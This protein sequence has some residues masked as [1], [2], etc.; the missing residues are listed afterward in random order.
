[1]ALP[2]ASAVKVEYRDGEKGPWK[3]LALAAKGGSLRG[4]LVMDVPVGTRQRWWR[5]TP[6]F[7]PSDVAQNL[8]LS[9]VLRK[10]GKKFGESTWEQ[11]LR[12]V[13]ILADGKGDGPQLSSSAWSE[14]AVRVR[15]LL[16]GPLD[17][18][19]FEAELSCTGAGG[20]N[21]GPC[22]GTDGEPGFVA[23][24]FD[25]GGWRPLEIGETSGV[26]PA[27][28]LLLQEAANIPAKGEKRYRFRLKATS[29]LAKHFDS[30]ALGF[31]MLDPKL[32]NLQDAVL[33]YG[34]LRIRFD[35][36]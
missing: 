26:T 10:G 36:S 2:G 3:R 27:K 5:I 15:N 31:R 24:Y 32:K 9:G 34:A 23:Q 8:E 18:L 21:E 30:G 6:A 22:D 4:A 35:A 13:D 20:E 14:Y 16:P 11:P 12:P 25:G 1:M 17:G 33:D 7:G 28:S 29:P 19:K